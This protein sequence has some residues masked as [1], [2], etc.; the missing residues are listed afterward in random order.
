MHSSLL[1]DYKWNYSTTI[2]ELRKDSRAVVSLNDS[3]VLRWLSKIN[4]TENSDDIA[5]QLKSE[6]KREKLNIDFFSKALLIYTNP[7]LRF[8]LIALRKVF[9]L[10]KK[11]NQTNHVN[12]S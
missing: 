1:N 10:F 9:S 3:Q 12:M 11:S 8:I 4:N 7:V 6:I 5:K 2:E